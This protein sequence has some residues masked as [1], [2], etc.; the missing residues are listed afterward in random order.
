MCGS[1]I[2]VCIKGGTM[3]GRESNRSCMMCFFVFGVCFKGSCHRPR[4]IRCLLAVRLIPRT[5]PRSVSLSG[6][7]SQIATASAPSCFTTN[8]CCEQPPTWIARCPTWCTTPRQCA[9]SC[10]SCSGGPSGFADSLSV[11][12]IINKPCWSS[13]VPASAAV[14]AGQRSERCRRAWRAPAES[15]ALP[16][17]HWLSRGTFEHAAGR[18][19]V[20]FDLCWRSGS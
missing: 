20:G 14:L 2:R 17:E 10:G 6:S 19:P 5:A 3:R 4:P 16:V 18:C 15:S 13:G 8:W 11:K 7:R 12:T 1:S 9:C